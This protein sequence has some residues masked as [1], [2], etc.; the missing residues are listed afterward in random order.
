MKS[1]ASAAAVPLAATARAVDRAAMVQRL[2][3]VRYTA[4]VTAWSLDDALGVIAAFDY[5]R[6][7]PD[8]PNGMQVRECITDADLDQ[9]HVAVNM[10][11]IAV[12][13][14]W[15]PFV[16]VGVPQWAAERRTKYYTAHR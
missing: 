7:L 15:Y 13:G 3:H 12:R 14:M 5:G 6:Y 2:A 9:P 1:A 16:A 11:P 10:G 8:D 4:G